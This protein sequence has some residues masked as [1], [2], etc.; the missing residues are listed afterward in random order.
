MTT[1]AIISFFAGFATAVAV[2]YM[3]GKRNRIKRGPRKA[4]PPHEPDADA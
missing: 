2:G 1:L 3:I 4:L